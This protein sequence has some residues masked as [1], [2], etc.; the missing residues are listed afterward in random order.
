MTS[1]QSTRSVTRVKGG[2][3][4]LI[5]QAT[6][7]TKMIDHKQTT[8]ISLMGTDVERIGLNLLQFHEIWASMIEIVVAVWLLERQVSLACFAPVIV[9]LGEW[10]SLFI[11]IVMLNSTASLSINVAVST[12]SKTAQ[13]AWIEMVQ[14]RLQTTLRVLDEMKAV[15]MLGLSDIMSKLVQSLRVSEI[16]VSAAYR[17][18]LVGNVLLCKDSP[19]GHNR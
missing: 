12:W 16:Q 7:D 2:L 9:I 6:I 15:K 1:Y 19:L 13:V 4:G 5:Y 11:S 10:L 17:R 8:A 18:L 3:L 14:S